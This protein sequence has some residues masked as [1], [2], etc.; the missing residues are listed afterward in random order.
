MPFV[1]QWS[2]EV[3]QALMLTDHEVARFTLDGSVL[4]KYTTQLDGKLPTCLHAW[5]NQADPCPWL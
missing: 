1:R 3:M 5:G 2:P 4:R